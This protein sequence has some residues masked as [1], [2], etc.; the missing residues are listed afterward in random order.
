[1]PCLYIWVMAAICPYHQNLWRRWEGSFF[2]P[3]F[4]TYSYGYGYPIP[5][6]LSY[7]YGRQPLWYGAPLQA[8]MGH[9]CPSDFREIMCKS[10]VISFMEYWY[11][12]PSLLSCKMDWMRNRENLKPTHGLLHRSRETRHQWIKFKFGGEYCESCESRLDS[13]LLLVH[14]K[15]GWV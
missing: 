6:G 9:V 11:P 10:W 15:T 1:M 5:I 8:T 4:V 14:P 12:F 3:L 7:M 2:Y 13:Y